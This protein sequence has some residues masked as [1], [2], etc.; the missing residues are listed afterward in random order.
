MTSIIKNV[1]KHP[2]HIV[3]PSPWPLMASIGCFLFTFGLVMFFHNY[4]TSIHRLH[5]TY[6]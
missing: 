2:Y 6:L 5:D 3:D 1:Q 4:S